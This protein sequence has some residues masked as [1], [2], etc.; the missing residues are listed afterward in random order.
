MHPQWFS[1]CVRS[2]VGTATALILQACGCNLVGCYDG[3]LVDFPSRPA[4]PYR[5]ELFAA[6]V[7]QS[8]PPE[9]TCADARGCYSGI[10]FRTHATDDLVLRVTTAIGVRDTA[11]PHV[12]YTT[13]APNG[14]G[15]GPICRSAMVTAKAPE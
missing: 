13:L 12:T 10:V 1:R 14:R 4:G 11:V 5:V 9:A 3:L 8:A 6:G 15:C 2:A 7:P